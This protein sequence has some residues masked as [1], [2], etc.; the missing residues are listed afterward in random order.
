MNSTLGSTLGLN[1]T[2]S[3]IEKKRRFAQERA[4][5]LKDPRIRQMGIDKQALEDQIKEKE[6]MKKM[7]KDRED[8]FNNQAVLMD[9]HAQVLQKEVDE[10]KANREK[11]AND[12]RQTFQKRELRR[13][14]DLNDPKRFQKEIPARVGD[15]DPRVGVSSLQKFSGEDL[16]QQQRRRAQA[17][18][19][20]EWSKQQIDEKTMKKFMERDAN[21]V[22]EDRSEE[23]AYRTWLVAQKVAD[24]RA[25]AAKTTAEFNKALAEQK[26]QEAL[27]FKRGETQKNLE[28]IYNMV[29][30]DMLNETESLVSSAGE[31]I[32]KERFKGMNQ[33]QLQRIFSEQASQRE[34]LRQRKMQE[35][36]DERQLSMQDAMNNRMALALDRQRQRETRLANQKL[37]DDRKAQ[38]EEARANRIKLNETYSNAV[39]EE[40]FKPFD[41]CLM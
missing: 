5:R 16:D 7:E 9:H 32:K 26:R 22:Y 27:Q 41:Q 15:D 1:T 24:Q 38:A 11:A 35:A 29:T 18:Q 6:A 19:Q 10:L 21:Q 34:E 4:Q 36:E 17:Q 12:Y 25:Q 39:G 3:T 28:E 37:A 20:Q 2:D 23:M 13:E 8:F 14:W 30:G 40:F 33:D 31:K